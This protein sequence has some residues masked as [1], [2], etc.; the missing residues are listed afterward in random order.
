M[1][2]VHVRPKRK[3][4]NCFF[5]QVRVGKLSLKVEV[6]H[7]L[8]GNCEQT[9]HGTSICSKEDRTAIAIRRQIDKPKLVAYLQENGSMCSQSQFH[10]YLWV[11]V[12]QYLSVPPPE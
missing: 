8:A 7:V 11:C 9:C 12:S 10:L 2:R 4:P 1:F 3:V 6:S 5:L